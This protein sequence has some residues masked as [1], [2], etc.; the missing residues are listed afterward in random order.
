MNVNT[1]GFI[2]SLARFEI[3]MTKY[4]L[5]RNPADINF[6]VWFVQSAR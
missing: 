6:S 2:F 3:L 1:L 5:I 4:G